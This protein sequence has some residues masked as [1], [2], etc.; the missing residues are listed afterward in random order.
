MEEEE[1]ERGLK[2]ELFSSIKACHFELI[3]VLF[4]Y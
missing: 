2:V 3:L 4:F 1:E